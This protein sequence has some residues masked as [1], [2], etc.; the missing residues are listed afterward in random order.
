M[1]E[2]DLAL[3]EKSVLEEQM[4]Q[5]KVLEPILESGLQMKPGQLEEVKANIEMG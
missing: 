1:E 4:K 5:M 3:E 2:L